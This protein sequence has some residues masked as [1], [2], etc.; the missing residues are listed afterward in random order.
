MTRT[1]FTQLLDALQE[2]GDAA[3]LTA[4]KALSYRRSRLM[5][6]YV[7]IV[8]PS[9]YAL[10]LYVYPERWF[11]FGVVRALHLVLGLGTLL[12]GR[13]VLTRLAMLRLAQAGAISATA[14]V[15]VMCALSEGFR[16]LYVVGMIICFLAI[17]TIEVFRPSQ[18][19]AVLL[20]IS[21]VYVWL[22]AVFGADDPR[23]A[24]AA[25]SFVAGAVLFC[26]VSAVLTEHHRRELFAAN[27]TLMEKNQDLARARELQGQFLSTVSHELR[28]PVHSML[29]FIELIQGREQSLHAK[30]RANLDRIKESGGRLLGFINDLLDLSKAEAGRMELRLGAFDLMTTVQEVAEATRALV[31]HRNLAVVVQG[32]AALWVHSDEQRVRQILTNLASNAAKFTEHGQVT[33]TVHAEHDIVLEVTDTGPGIAPESRSVIFEAFR[34]VGVSAGGTGLGLSIVQHLVHLL[35]GTIDLESELGKGSTFR[36]RLGPIA[37]GV[38]A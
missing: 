29:G 25:T 34:Q 20:G 18:L 10:D 37:I 1:A 13:R 27:V 31:L 11:D 24:V 33:M 16:S 12:A 21:T 6:G 2:S 35:D 4:Q 8:Y 3:Y 28:S 23:N 17:S 32:P 9:F 30:S 5:L 15:A 19:I 36:V 7:G 14:N 26:G 38:A 22:N